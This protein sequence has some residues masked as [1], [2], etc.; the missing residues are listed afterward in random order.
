MVTI[1]RFRGMDLLVYSNDHAPAHAHVRKSGEW[2]LKIEFSKEG[3]PSRIMEDAYSG[4][5]PSKWRKLAIKLVEDNLDDC[6]NAW[7]RFHHD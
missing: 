2:T 1:A 6:Q 7:N 3:K 5:V 4:L